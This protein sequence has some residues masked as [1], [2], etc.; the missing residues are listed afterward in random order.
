MKVFALGLAGLLGAGTAHAVSF[1]DM[2]ARCGEADSNVGITECYFEIYRAQDA[3]LN[4]IYR[5]MISAYD[6]EGKRKLQKAQRAWIV[7]RDA[8]CE[9]EADTLRGGTGAHPLRASCLAK[10]TFERVRWLKNL[11]PEQSPEE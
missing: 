3:E 11:S 7:T 2:S 6:A 4:K 10:A 5:E 1:D 9:V 8:D